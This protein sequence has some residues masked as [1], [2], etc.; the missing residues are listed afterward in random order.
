MTAG[1]H[2]AGAALTA[3]SF[4]LWGRD[5]STDL[6]ST[7]CSYRVPPGE[8]LLSARWPGPCTCGPMRHAAI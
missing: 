8:G 7:L 5:R 6:Y 4:G 2:L 3:T 1:T